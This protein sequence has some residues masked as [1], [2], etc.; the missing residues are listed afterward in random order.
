MGGA[1]RKHSGHRPQR[2]N[3]PES[4]QT[5]HSATPLETPPR[6]AG[7]SLLLNRK[8]AHSTN[9]TAKMQKFASRY[10]KNWIVVENGGSEHRTTFPASRPQYGVLP[11]RLQA[12]LVKMRIC[13][14]SP[15]LDTGYSIKKN[16]A[17]RIEHPESIRGV[18][19]SVESS[20]RATNRRAT[21]CI[22]WGVRREL[23]EQ[24]IAARVGA[25]LARSRIPA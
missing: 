20:C 18:Y 6:R 12:P 24:T 10:R 23:D 1:S 15:M 9:D 17:S 21:L 3:H 19:L 13:F 8:P 16:P 22:L 4:I 7:K 11:L 25:V 2:A 5:R 14:S